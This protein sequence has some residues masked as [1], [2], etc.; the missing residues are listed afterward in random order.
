MVRSIYVKNFKCFEN[1]FVECRELNLFT[2]INGR[3]KSTIIQAL[4]L[5]Y[6]TY[7]RV[8]PGRENHALLNGKYVSLGTLKDMLNG[9][10]LAVKQGK[11][12]SGKVGSES[13][14]SAPK[15][16]NRKLLYC[17]SKPFIIEQET[18]Q[19]ENNSTEGGHNE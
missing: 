4:L 13:E 16:V 15:K 1:I 5:L 10:R 12:Q 7:E 2:G 3:G 14:S 18:S 11:I 17:P 9:V 19:K 6:Q 8:M